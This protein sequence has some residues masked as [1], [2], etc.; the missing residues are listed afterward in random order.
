[1]PSAPRPSAVTPSPTAKP[2]TL[3]INI[4]GNTKLTSLTYTVNGERTKL[5]NVT[6][7]WRTVVEVPPRPQRARWRMSFRFRPGKINW[8]VLVDG[9]EVATGVNAAAGAPGSDTVK[10]TG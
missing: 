7:P 9:F 2:R 10:G 8:R 1:M 5:T 4:T 6:L 3:E